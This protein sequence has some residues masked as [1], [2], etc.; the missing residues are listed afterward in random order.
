MGFSKSEYWSGLPVGFLI[1]GISP[2]QVSNMGLLY[3]RQILYLPGY[4]EALHTHTHTHPHTH[5]HIC[6]L[7]PN[8][9]QTGS[10]LRKEFIKAVYWHTAYLAYIHTVHQAKCWAGWSSCWNRDCR[11]NINNLRY[12][13]YTVLMAE[14]EEEVKSR[15]INVKKE[16]KSWLKTQHSK[17]I[18]ASSPI[19]S[20]QTGKHWK[21]WHTLS[22]AP[23]SM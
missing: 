15:L 1:Q 20:W 17:S 7:E 5:T 22:W 13:D 21:Q 19:N 6:K 11:V 4:Q 18:M 14:S 2:T 3:C 9:E 8:R 10:K 23:K 12:A 16:W